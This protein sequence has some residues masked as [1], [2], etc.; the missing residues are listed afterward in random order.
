MIKIK[1]RVLSG[2][3]WESL[4]L[5]LT[6]N[7]HAKDIEIDFISLPDGTAEVMIRIVPKKQWKNLN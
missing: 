6:E 2:A 4:A 5:I 3:D 1:Y 7:G